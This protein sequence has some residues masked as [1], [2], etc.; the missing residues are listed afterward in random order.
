MECS[1]GRFVLFTKDIEHLT[2]QELDGLDCG[3]LV[4]KITGK[5]RH[6]YT[7]SYKGEGSGE[8]ICLTYCAC[9]YIETI[10]YDRTDSGWAFNS[11]D[12]WQAE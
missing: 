7:V 11:K 12:V 2:A 1:Y 3:D 6:A 9:G 8:G 10:S 5:Q 4:V